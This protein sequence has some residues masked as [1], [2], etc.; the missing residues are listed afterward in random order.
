MKLLTDAQA[1]TAML[2]FLQQVY[3]R[4]QGDE[5]GGL[6]GGMS[7]LADGRPADLGILEDWRR[8]VEFAVEGGEADQLSIRGQDE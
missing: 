6:L 3:C 8:A 1:Y 7:Q 5:L 2:R 4:T